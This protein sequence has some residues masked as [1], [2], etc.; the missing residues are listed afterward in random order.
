M[1]DDDFKTAASSVNDLRTNFARL[2][3]RWKTM[4]QQQT[5]RRGSI[6]DDDH[7]HPLSSSPTL[8]PETSKSTMDDHLD[9]PTRQA[10]PT[11]PLH[12]AIARDVTS[13]PQVFSP[14]SYATPEKRAKYTN[15]DDTSPE[16]CVSLIPSPLLISRQPRM[17][18]VEPPSTTRRI[19]ALTQENVSRLPR[20]RVPTA[21]DRDAGSSVSSSHSQTS[22]ISKYSVKTDGAVFDRLYQPNHL[23]D[24]DLRMNLHQ[25]RQRSKNC[26]FK[27]RTNVKNSQPYYPSSSRESVGSNG[28]AASAQTDITQG[29]SATSRLYDPDYIR[30]RHAKLEK[31]KLERELRHCTFVPRTNRLTNERMLKSPGSSAPNSPRKASSS[32]RTIK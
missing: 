23:Q 30:K 1:L 19:A 29:L 16:R 10:A 13:I 20:A 9:S 2:E 17:S 22:R 15:D 28:S 11:T 5:Q 7:D 18:P 25:Q 8:I 12:T 14:S 6:V 26:P 31:L 24:R 21:M 4:R 32:S 3:Q 27:P